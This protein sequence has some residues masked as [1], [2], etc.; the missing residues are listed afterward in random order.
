VE[1]LWTP[2]RREFIEKSSGTDQADGCFLCDKPRQDDDRA[3]LILLREARVYVLLNL[4]P[5]N[6]GHLLVAPYQHTGDFASLEPQTAAD[7]MHLSQ[8]SVAALEQVYRPHAFNLGM[9][10]GREAGAGLPDHLHI[11]IVPRWNGDTN[12]MPLVAETKV[13]PESLDQTYGRLLPA[14]DGLAAS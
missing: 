10:L 1:R 8:K 4:Y 3:N 11:H 6:S 5:Y 13:L 12:F 14:F 7:L 2:W 9:N